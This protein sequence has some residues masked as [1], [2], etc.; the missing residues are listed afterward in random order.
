M[1]GAVGGECDV[2]R[3]IAESGYMPG[4]AVYALRV[5]LAGPSFGATGQHFDV[6]LAMAR[7]SVAHASAVLVRK[8]IAADTNLAG[9]LLSTCLNMQGVY[10]AGGC[11]L[12]SVFGTACNDVDI[13]VAPG[14]LPP[15]GHAGGVPRNDVASAAGKNSGSGA[16]SASP[17]FC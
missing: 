17:L 7:A 11:A 15:A 10:L 2:W 4:S 9:K 14:A 1:S 16:R 5:A 6:S 12:A 3:G 8:R 13:F